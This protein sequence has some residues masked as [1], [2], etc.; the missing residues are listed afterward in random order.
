MKL[1]DE[2]LEILKNNN[3]KIISGNEIATALNVS[4]TA[5]WKNIEALRN[6][7]YNISAGTNSG[8]LLIN[9]YDILDENDIKSYLTAK[10]LGGE[11]EIL[12]SVASTNTYAKEK[13]SENAPNGT[14]I[15][16]NVQ[17]GGKG[18]L[19]KNFYSPKG[20]G[21]YMS[22]ILRP[23]FTTE[24]SLLITSIVAVA[25]ASAIEE[26]CE[27]DCKIKWVND[28]YVSGKKICGILTE[29]AVNFEVGGL[30]YVVVGIGVNVSGEDF[31]DDISNIASSIKLQNGKTV[32]RNRLIAEILNKIEIYLSDIT[33]KKS[34]EEYKSRSIV[35]GKRISVQK[36]EDIY[37]ASCIGIDDY[38]RLIL[39]H[40]DG[41]LETLLSGTIRTLDM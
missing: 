11:I 36:N 7:G 15:L 19:G 26:L 22:L 13:A 31:P 24:Q 3:G 39:K 37:E 21:I 14:V 28:I 41:K 32:S 35:I 4:R 8:Y 10:S 40:D 2:I 18:R 27:L 20:D 6:D 34:L 30:D 29:A 16:S 12:K 1:K 33:S 9:D 25:V 17:T 38:C 5:I 23:N